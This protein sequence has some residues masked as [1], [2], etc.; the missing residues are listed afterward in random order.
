MRL[1]VEKAQQLGNDNCE[2]LNHRI[3]LLARQVPDEKELLHYK[4][5]MQD[6]GRLQAEL[7]ELIATGNM[8]Q[9]PRGNSEPDL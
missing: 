4:S 6:Y 8:A 3:D 9:L 5:T 2:M 7:Q 1:E